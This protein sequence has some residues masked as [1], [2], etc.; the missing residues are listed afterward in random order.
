MKN[1]KED[2]AVVYENMIKL[3]YFFLKACDFVIHANTGLN[4]YFVN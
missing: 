3:K 4:L 1:T 2:M